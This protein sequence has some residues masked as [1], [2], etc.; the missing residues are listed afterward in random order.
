VLRARRFKHQFGGAMRQA[1]MA[2]AACVYALDHHVDRLADDH[3][4]AR[5]LAEAL[6]EA[7]LPVD[8]E[9]VETNFVQIDVGALGLS[10][11]EAMKRLLD[12][13]VRLSTTMGS[14]LRAVTHLDISDDDIERAAELIPRALAVPARV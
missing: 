5:R 10:Q 14:R 12:E 3:A 6:V 1:G 2:A 9:Q 8:L 13:G 4:R 11:M 7:G